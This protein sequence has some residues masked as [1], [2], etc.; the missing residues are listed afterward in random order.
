M[1]KSF[2]DKAIAAKARAMYGSR[3]TPD[4]YDQL[5]KRSTV[6]E[7]AAYLR[8][9]TYYG[10]VLDKA[11]L[12]AIHRGQLE[13][14]L[15]RERAARYARLI[16]YDFAREPGFFQY[17]FLWDEVTQLIDQLR[18]IAAG[19]Q[20]TNHI[21]GQTSPFCS[22]ARDAL[23]RARTWQEAIQ[24]LEGTDYHRILL[25]YFPRDGQDGTRPDIVA[26]DRELTIYYYRK[27]FDCID[28]QFGKSTARQLRNI[29]LQ[30]IGMRNI[31]IAYRLR[32][33]FNSPDQTVR[34]SLLPFVT[35][36]HKLV[37]QL[38]AA[39]PQDLDS[40][41]RASFLGALSREGELEPVETLT[42]RMRD[43]ASRRLLRYS[44]SAP[45][46]LTAY[47]TQ[48]EVELSNIIHIVEGI[49]YQ[50]PPQEIARMIVL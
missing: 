32:R 43:Q 34:D 37:E 40:L 31:A 41:L 39:R 14:M 30:R 4:D 6:P 26:L 13:E 22:Y 9:N 38:I 49:R 12:T 8:D 23:L 24:L 15:R 21:R 10:K 5:M 7:A 45:V 44:T 28:R 25:Q 29:F 42:L 2:S 20:G 48:M 46:V 35:P 3:L 36:S 33:F 16:H 1:L 18:Y 27:V 47:A 19:S 11:D 50:L 17:L